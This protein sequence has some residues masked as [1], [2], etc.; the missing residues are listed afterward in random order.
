[1]ENLVPAEQPETSSG[2]DCANCGQPAM[3]GPHPTALCSEC[4][5][6]L[7]R[8]TIPL[9]VKIFMGAIGALL[10]FALYTLPGNIALGMHLHR[11]EKAIEQKNY[12]TAENELKLVTAKTPNNVEA[13]GH[14]LLA[15]FYNQDFEVLNEAYKKLHMVNIDDG[16][17]LAKID[18]VLDKAAR[19]A[20]GDSF[21]NFTTAHPQL[22][23]VTDTAW[24]NYFAGN[25]N[26]PYAMMEYSS[27]LYDKENYAAVDS[28]TNLVLKVDN[29]Y[30]AAL[31][32]QT[33]ARRELGDM[34]GA[35]AVGEKMLSLNHES[36]RGLSTQARTL[37]R[38]KKDELALDMAL[39]ASQIDPENPYAR[40]TLIL[41]Y[42]FN[43]RTGDRDALMKRSRAA[44]VGD[45]TE[46]TDLQYA[47]DVI[48][49]K[50]K[51]RD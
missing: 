11:G 49:H 17:L 35:L 24:R 48:D 50:E 20:P 39:K 25:A 40:A 33:S 22:P 6:Q 18:F 29:E 7:T 2:R 41:A 31:M 16:E 1:M 4:R 34:E 27:L 46:K 14:L 3:K 28:M 44:A 37:L 5:E 42:H 45:S 8:L 12:N 13:N 19:Y 23:A 21:E 43:G 38:M 15:A 36:V 9:W 30:F 26:D 47:L 32:M 51:F 10:L